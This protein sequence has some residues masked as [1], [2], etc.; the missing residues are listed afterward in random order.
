MWISDRRVEDLNAIDVD[1]V[2]AD[3][4]A[5]DPDA[6]EAPTVCPECLG[7][8]LRTTLPQS[9]LF[10][11]AFKSGLRLQAD[12]NTLV[13]IGTLSAYAYSVVATFFPSWFSAHLVHGFAAPPGSTIRPSTGSASGPSSGIRTDS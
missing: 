6:R 3:V 1:R 4:L 13:A 7:D 2:L 12:M 8:L 5:N 10:V 11:S 9:D